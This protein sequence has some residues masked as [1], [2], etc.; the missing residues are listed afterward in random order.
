MLL[1][2]MGEN[3]ILRHAYAAEPWYGPGDRACLERFRSKGVEI[4]EYDPIGETLDSVPKDEGPDTSGT[5]SASSRSPAPT[6][7]E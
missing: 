1:A 3:F 5:P 4:L 6:P 7:G 2:G